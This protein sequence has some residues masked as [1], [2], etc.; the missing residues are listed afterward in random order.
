MDSDQLLQDCDSDFQV[1][2]ACPHVS[3]TASSPAT[4]YAPP[5]AHPPR[6]PHEP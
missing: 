4:D 6:R 5:S 2:L 1:V 3:L